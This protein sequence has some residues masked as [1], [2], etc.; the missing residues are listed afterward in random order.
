M[1]T[2]LLGFRAFHAAIL[3]P[4]EDGGKDIDPMIPANRW[5]QF[6]LLDSWNEMRTLWVHS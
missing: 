2:L 6:P 1:R 3:A 5:I 4:D